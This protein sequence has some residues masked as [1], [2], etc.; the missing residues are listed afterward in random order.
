MTMQHKNTFTEDEASRIRKLLHQ[1]SRVLGKSEQKKIR[2]KLRSIGFYI[3]DYNSDQS[4][5][6]MFDFED[7]IKIGRIKIVKAQ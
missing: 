3:T 4:G 1:K 2:D 7:L 6:T 5:F